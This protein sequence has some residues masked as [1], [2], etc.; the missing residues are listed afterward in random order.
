VLVGRIPCER[1]FILDDLMLRG[2]STARPTETMTDLDPARSSRQ[3]REQSTL[4][5]WEVLR[6][7]S[8]S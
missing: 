6:E 7:R 3:D 4:S 5:G 2:G 1:G 8:A